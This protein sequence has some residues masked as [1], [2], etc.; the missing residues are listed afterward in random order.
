[1]GVCVPDEGTDEGNMSRND[2][3]ALFETW[4]EDASENAPFDP[5]VMSLATCSAAGKPSVRM[6]L[7]RG[8]REGGFSFFTN[9]ESRKG[10]ELLENSAA[11]VAFYWPHLG[12]QVRIEGRVERLSV[13][14]SD[15]YFQ[16]RPLGS[17]ITAAVSRQSRPLVN[18]RE[19]LEQIRALEQSNTQSVPRPSH[20]GGYKLIPERFEFWIHRDNRRHDRTAFVREH[21]SWVVTKLYP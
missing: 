6:V 5:D 15:R 19:F 7:F 9:Y 2:P 16:S 11:A 18:E 13:G 3:F 21:D 10:Q 14:E 8:L 17:Q 20:W 12:K 4:Y 1:M